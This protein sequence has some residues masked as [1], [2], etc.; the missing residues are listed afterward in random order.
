MTLTRAF[1]TEVRY[2]SAAFAYNAGAVAGGGLTPYLA[3]QLTQSAGPRAAG[4][5]VV[6]AAVTGLT[7]MSVLTSRGRAST[8]EPLRLNRVTDAD[9]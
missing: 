7:V 6:A 5:L 9:N 3:A 1:P 8:D 4:W 2:T